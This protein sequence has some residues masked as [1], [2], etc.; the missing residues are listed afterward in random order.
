[1]KIRRFILFGLLITLCGVFS[2]FAVTAPPISRY[3]QKQQQKEQ[4]AKKAA[5]TAEASKQ[6]EKP[7]QNPVVPL[8]DYKYPV[9]EI[10]PQT[11]DQV[12]KK[13][14]VELRDPANIKT[15]VVYDPATGTYQ[16]VTKLGEEIISTP[17]SLLA[18][19]KQNRL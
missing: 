10:I 7:T 4:A 13:T 19:Q 5:A 17:I 18:L 6:K 8:K 12:G 1:L 14:A 15:E 11:L 3:E 2:L 16:I 9:S